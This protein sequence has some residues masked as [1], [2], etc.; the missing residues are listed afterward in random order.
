[1]P[2][3]AKDI[4]ANAP[5]L[6]QAF[7]DLGLLPAADTLMQGIR[8]LDAGSEAI[9]YGQPEFSPISAMPPPDQYSRPGLRPT[10]GVAAGPQSAQEARD[11]SS[12]PNV[13]NMAIEASGMG[14]AGRSQRAFAEGR[15]LEG[16]GH[17]AVAALPY[18]PAAGLALAG[19]AYAT[20][21]GQTLAPGIFGASGAEAQQPDIPSQFIPMDRSRFFQEN[22][23]PRRTLA[24]LQ[25]EA[26]TRVT[27]NPA[28]QGLVEDGKRTQATRMIEQARANAKKT[29]D[30]QEASLQGEEA[31]LEGA[32]ET[33]LKR[34]E[35]Q[36]N[37]YVQ[38]RSSA[39]EYDRAV[40]NA[41]RARAE[42]EARDVQWKDTP[43]GRLNEAMGGYGPMLLGGVAGGI[44]RSAGR[45]MGHGDSFAS[46]YVAPA[47]TG[48]FAG[49]TAVNAPVIYNATQ[50][51][52]MNPRRRAL[53][54]YAAALPP[55]HPRK[56][57]T[58]A[59]LRDTTSLPPLNPIRQEA[60]EQLGLWPTVRRTVSG[61]VL[62]GAPGGVMGSEVVRRL[63]NRRTGGTT[64]D[65][66]GG[67]GGNPPPPPP[68][69]QQ[70]QRD[71]N[72]SVP[73]AAPVAPG[74]VETWV[75]PAGNKVVT[76]RSNG[77]WSE[78][79]VRGSATPPQQRRGW[80]R[81]ALNDQIEAFGGYP[82][83]PI[84]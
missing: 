82:V 12:E 62:E 81:I 17:A 76:K 19:G 8:G 18:R 56:A 7:A 42:W 9:D 14:P 49:G 13:Y 22:R 44:T 11:I 5:A 74:E 43:V 55:D 48:G 71:R 68:T 61:A 16:V 70:R 40:A 27:S 84:G 65:T 60:T 35:E 39:A 41:E 78:Q 10:S 24:D 79:G 52:V 25:T 4:Q 50:P 38:G 21:L 51:E 6:Q 46:H 2:W 72:Y 77:T 20:A 67:G 23:A 30:Q 26:E 1:M 80:R 29:F 75:S 36:K 73:P 57:D 58:E 31:R 63:G 37:K 47:L 69:L 64:G 45:V 3:N 66:G 15:P 34:L 32:Y 28:Y 59:R 53:E 33:Y 83:E 54:E